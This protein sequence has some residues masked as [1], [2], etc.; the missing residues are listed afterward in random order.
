MGLSWHWDFEGL[1]ISPLSYR[2]LISRLFASQGF[3]EQSTTEPDIRMEPANVLLVRVGNCVDEYT[4]RR[5]FSR[6]H[7]SPKLSRQ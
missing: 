2:K 4:T 1:G 6:I 7:S 5:F 3:T